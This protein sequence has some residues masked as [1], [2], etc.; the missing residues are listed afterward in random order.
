MSE[1]LELLERISCG[2][3][4]ERF[5]NKGPGQVVLSLSE[6]KREILK[7]LT[8]EELQNIRPDAIWG[9]PEQIR[10]WE[11]KYGGNRNY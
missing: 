9:T 4:T 6:E 1:A 7:G 3:Y 2:I 10:E 8:S 11:R 5:R